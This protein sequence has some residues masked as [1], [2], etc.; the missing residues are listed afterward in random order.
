MVSTLDA[1]SAGDKM[2][3]TCLSFLGLGRT[4]RGQNQSSMLVSSKCDSLIAC[5]TPE[6]NET[7]AA[8]ESQQIEPPGLTTLPTELVLLIAEILPLVDA[9]CLA[10]TCKRMCNIADIS[11]LAIRLDANGTNTLLCRLER[12]TADFSYCFMDQ[13]LKPAQFAPHKPICFYCHFHQ[14][15]DPE[16]VL[17]SYLFFHV[18][19]FVLDY[20]TARI[21]TNHQLLGPRHG[22]PASYLAKTYNHSP[23]WAE[24]ISESEVWAANVIHGELFLS[25]IH[26]SFHREANAGALQDYCNS[27]S[28][29]IQMCAHRDVYGIRG[30]GIPTD[31]IG[32]TNHQVSG[33]CQKCETDWEVNVWWADSAQ[34]WT[35]TVETYHKLGACRS[36]Q[37][38]KW[39]AMSINRK[40]KAYRKEPGGGV[41]ELWEQHKW[42]RS[43]GGCAQHPN[44]FASGRG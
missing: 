41:K 15:T 20:C 24:E 2:V 43:C 42:K 8:R 14:A 29:S 30:T 5:P 28:G 34:S 36:P 44:H 25:C 40:Q 16:T 31:L 4:A 35:V 11:N 10:L 23:P 18:G 38:Q 19:L 22:V 17:E 26:T 21:V 33:W 13:K 37:D 6:T 12:D 9:L 39:Q 32:K 7:P 3:W 1:L 27:L